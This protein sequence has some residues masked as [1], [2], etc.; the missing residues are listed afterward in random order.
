[1]FM[2]YKVIA[3][4]IHNSETGENTP[5]T[6]VPKDPTRVPKDPTT[7]RLNVDNVRKE[8]MPSGRHEGEVLATGGEGIL[9][10]HTTS[11]EKK[12]CR[13][14]TEA[15]KIAAAQNLSFSRHNA[16]GK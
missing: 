10:A 6:R 1:M 2:Y 3:L 14:K 12:N 16:G 13:E 9:F 5:Q 8:T 4:H 11:C 7:G 15:C